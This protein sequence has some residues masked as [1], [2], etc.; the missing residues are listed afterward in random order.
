MIRDKRPYR[1]SADTIKLYGSL[2]HGQNTDKS[3]KHQKSAPVS[4]WRN[5]LRGVDLNH[6]PLGYEG[7]RKVNAMQ[8]QQT[9][10]K[11]IAD[12]VSL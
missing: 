6:R 2:K 1:L 12:L 3:K 4:H 11:K 10:F 8:A 5:W 7:K 9:M